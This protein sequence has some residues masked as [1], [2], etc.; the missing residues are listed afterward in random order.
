MLI[1]LSTV[2]TVVKVVLQTA[3]TGWLFEDLRKWDIYYDA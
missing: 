3:V 2:V 1:L